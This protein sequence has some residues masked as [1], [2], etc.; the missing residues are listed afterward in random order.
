M[1][2]IEA[3]NDLYSELPDTSRSST[4][5]EQNMETSQSMFIKL[6]IVKE[7]YPNDIVKIELDED[8][9]QNGMTVQDLKEKIAK[10]CG[11]Q[12]PDSFDL[13]YRKDIMHK[14]SPLKEKRL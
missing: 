13:T 8:E 6:Q 4:F 14:K 7:D 9:I 1:T 2:D 5:H 12:N 3:D 10:K 11:P